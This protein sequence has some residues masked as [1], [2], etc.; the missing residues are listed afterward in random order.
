MPFYANEEEYNKLKDI[1]KK[2][3]FPNF[4]ELDI[5]T[6]NGTLENRYNIVYLSNIIEGIVCYIVKNEIFCDPFLENITE[7]AELQR[8]LKSFY[9]I[10]KKNGMFL[11]DYR[12][13]VNRYDAIDYMFNNPYFNAHEI[14]SKYLVDKKP[15]KDLVLTYKPKEKDLFWDN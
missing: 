11:V 4:Y 9:P 6:F 10:L 8:I 12:P 13:N 2:S 7:Q 1:L 3:G 14:A 5:S 15:E